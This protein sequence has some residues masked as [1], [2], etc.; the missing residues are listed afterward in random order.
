[1][2]N[3]LMRQPR[4]RSLIHAVVFGGVLGL[5]SAAAAQTAPDNTKVNKR[6]RAEGAVTA[7]QQKENAAD[8]E[9]AKK[10]RAAITDDDALSTY[11]H[12]VKIIV[13]DGKVTLKG[14]VRTAA[15]KTAVAAKAIEIAG[16]KDH[17][18]NSLSIAPDH[19]KDKDKTKDADKE[20]PKTR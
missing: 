19:D 6:D 3:T 12:N 17:V 15:E 7:D 9:L 16:G 10:I 8:R 13:R 4:H 18:T 5:A 2:E 11:A 1:M 14:P 20:K